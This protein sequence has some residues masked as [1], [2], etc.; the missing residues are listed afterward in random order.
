MQRSLVPNPGFR[1]KTICFVDEE[2]ASVRSLPWPLA[3]VA[4]D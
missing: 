1:A 2:G 4:T 3:A